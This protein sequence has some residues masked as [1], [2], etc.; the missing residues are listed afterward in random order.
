VELLEDRTVPAAPVTV[1]DTFAVHQGVTLNVVANGVLA[2][3]TDADNDTLNAALISAPANG[4]FVLYSD[5]GFTF[6]PNPGFAGSDSFT[7]AANDGNSN[8]NTVTVTLNVTNTTPAAVADAFSVHQGVTLNVAA[9]GVLANDSD[10]DSSDTLTAAVVTAP[11]NGYFVLYS[12]GSFTFSPNPGFSGTDSFTYAANDGATNSNTVTVTLYITNVAPV[13]QGESYEVEHGQTLNVTAANGVLANDS[14]EDEEDDDNL[15]AIVDTMP[16]NGYFILY[17]DGSF[18]YSPNPGFA[19]TDIFKYWANDGA[20]NSNLVTVALNVPNTPPVAENFTVEVVHGYTIN[21][22]LS[23]HTTDAETASALLAYSIVQNPAQGQGSGQLNGAIYSYTATSS[24]LATVTFTYRANDGE[25]NSNVRTVTVNVTNRPPSDPIDLDIVANR[26]D[27]GAEQDTY[28]GITLYAED[29]DG[30]DGSISLVG[31]NSTRF[32]IVQEQGMPSHW[33]VYVNTYVNFENSDIQENEFGVK[34]YMVTARSTDQFGMH[35]GNAQFFIAVNNLPPYWPNESDDWSNGADA[36]ADENAVPAMP[37]A[38]ASTHIRARAK[39]P[40]DPTGSPTSLTYSFAEGGNSDGFFSINPTTGVVTIADGTDMN[41]YDYRY[42][43]LT[44][45][46]K[47]PSMAPS[48]PTYFYVGPTLYGNDDGPDWSGVSQDDELADCWYIAAL[49][50]LAHDDPEYV[51]AMIRPMADVNPL[52][53]EVNLFDTSTSNWRWIGVDFNEDSAWPYYAESNGI[54]VAVLEK[55]FWNM[56]GEDELNWNVAGAAIRP[57]TGNDWHS[58]WFTAWDEVEEEWYWTIS[59]EDLFY[60]I[61]SL[62]NNDPASDNGLAIVGYDGHAYSV[63]GVGWEEDEE[64]EDVWWPVVYLRDPYGDRSAWSE[65]GLFWVDL[66]DFRQSVGGISYDARW[67]D[68]ATDYDEQLGKPSMSSCTDDT[69]DEALKMTHVSDW[70]DEAFFARSTK[71][72]SGTA[73]YYPSSYSAD[74]TISQP[75]R[76]YRKIE[77]SSALLESKSPAADKKAWKE[78]TDFDIWL[79]NNAAHLEWERARV[80]RRK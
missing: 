28:V 11:A 56:Y 26:V 59:E 19:G 62:R 2:N 1:A 49:V 51:K 16:A 74:P 40:G 79:D 48:S 18:T 45:V 9:S 33:G 37:N 29:P 8:G 36:D 68:V 47:D 66:S 72:F 15:T 63:M 70:V 55:A 76:S 6:S 7:Y 13:A 46:A 53:F 34:G 50:E 69:S 35:S 43:G 4:Y 44:V 42:Y 24:S 12:D 78:T 17:A 71:S 60:F 22:D 64:E 73:D 57:L 32:K 61:G 80:V 39:D 38:N 14:D 67:D 52:S 5:G 58:F 54:W 77:K 65:D 25:F 3:D 75:P 20:A 10:A 31:A 41:F 23:A 30:D 27:E 21:I